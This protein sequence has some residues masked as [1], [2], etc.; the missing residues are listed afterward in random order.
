MLFCYWSDRFWQC[1]KEALRRSTDVCNQS[2][3]SIKSCPVPWIKGRMVFVQDKIYW[4][5]QDIAHNAMTIQPLPPHWWLTCIWTLRKDKL[6]LNNLVNY[7]YNIDRLYYVTAWLNQHFTKT[8]H[9]TDHTLYLLLLRF[10]RL[11]YTVFQCSVW[12]R[13]TA[14]DATWKIILKSFVLNAISIKLSFEWEHHW[15]GTTYYN[16]WYSN[17]KTKRFILKWDG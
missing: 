14:Y 11:S 17:I 15:F 8:L 12:D 3:Q 5:T 1:G 16:L 13:K 4:C 6:Y 10:Y 9:L 7:M 2:G